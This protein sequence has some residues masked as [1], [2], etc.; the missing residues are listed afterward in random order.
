MV[1]YSSRVMNYLYLA[2]EY[3]QREHLLVD[4]GFGGVTFLGNYVYHQIVHSASNNNPGK[5]M[6]KRRPFLP[7]PSMPRYLMG[8]SPRAEINVTLQTVASQS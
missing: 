4:T 5:A 3:L 2:A 1:S 8:H 6:S 7:R